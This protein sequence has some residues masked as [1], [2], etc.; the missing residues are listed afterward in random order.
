MEKGLLGDG[1]KKGGMENRL[2]WDGW[3]E[4]VTEINF[5]VK[6]M[7]NKIKREKRGGGVLRRGQGDTLRRGD[8]EGRGK[9]KRR[10]CVWKF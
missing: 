3:S 5:R 2:L 1:G 10:N 4:Y 7:I 6:Q 8:G 9:G